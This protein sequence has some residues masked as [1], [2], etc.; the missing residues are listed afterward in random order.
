M[1]S[2]CP[3][4][5]FYD[6]KK[7]K[8]HQKFPFSSILNWSPVRNQPSTNVSVVAFVL[9]RY[10]LLTL[11]PRSHSS[12]ASL[13]SASVPS[14]RT[15][16]ASMPAARIPTDP[17]I[18]WS[19]PSEEKGCIIAPDVCIYEI[20]LTDGIRKKSTHKFRHAIPCQPIMVRMRW[21]YKKKRN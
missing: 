20:I 2:A 5:I 17:G 15:V 12:P 1:K 7:V 10:P 8:T 16:R 11:P 19:F 6:N 18:C 13:T 9:F 14:S 4:Y 3:S 21:M